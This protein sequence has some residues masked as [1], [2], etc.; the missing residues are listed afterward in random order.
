MPADF[1]M[2]ARGA[3]LGDSGRTI[4]AA[5]AGGPSRYASRAEP[6]PAAMTSRPMI[7]PTYGHVRSRL[8]MG[9]RTKSVSAAVHAVRGQV[10]LLVR[11]GAR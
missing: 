8:W 2:V 4:A 10:V 3:A 9:L 1:L 11:E 6:M 5:G 7:R